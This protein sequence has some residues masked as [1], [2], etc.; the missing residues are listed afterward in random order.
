[1]RNVEKIM[2]IKGTVYFV[3]SGSVVKEYSTFWA[4]LVAQ[5]AQ[6]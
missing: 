3:C 1:M 6:Q 5:V 4:D 2:K